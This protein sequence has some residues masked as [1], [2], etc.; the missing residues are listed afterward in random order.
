MYEWRK[1]TDE[2]RARV[3]AERK[4][5]RLPWHSPPHLEFAG[6]VT[7]II[8]A[9]CYEHKHIVGKCPERM[10]E[11]EKDILDVCKTVDQGFPIKNETR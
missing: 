6:D 5:R 10:A 9:A 7:F 1:M 2:E 4:G 11:F 8:T 3:L